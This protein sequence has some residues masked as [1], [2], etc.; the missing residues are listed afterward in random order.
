MPSMTWAG[1]AHVRA[2]GSAAI[3]LDL[4][5]DRYFRVA[6]DK[7]FAGTDLL[8]TAGV[9]VA[10]D[11][12]AQARLTSQGLLQDGEIPRHPASAG[13]MLDVLHACAWADL[14]LRLK[15]LHHAIARLSYLKLLGREDRRRRS[16]EAFELW[17]PLYP[18]NYVCLIDSLALARYLLLGGMR[19]SFV[20]GVRDAPFS[21]HAW[22]ALDGEV[23]NDR[24]GQWR[25]YQ[26][27]LQI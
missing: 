17:R 12:R 22:V 4:V 5:A 20:I 19:P 15:R 7:S 2:L 9:P 24:L 13:D 3:I 6:L 1:R 11:A 14:Q 25:S 10:L 26:P 21:A 23:V 18:H 16:L 8:D 27:I